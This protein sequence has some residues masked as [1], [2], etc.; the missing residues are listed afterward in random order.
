MRIIDT[1]GIGDTT[2]NTEKFMVALYEALANIDGELSCIVMV[3]RFP[4]LMNAEYRN[5]LTFYRDI[6]SEVYH[7]SLITFIAVITII[8]RITAALLS[9]LHRGCCRYLL[10]YPKV[11]HK[12]VIVVLNAFKHDPEWQDL[13]R[14][15]LGSDPMET[16][17]LLEEEVRA[18]FKNDFYY[19]LRAFDPLGAK[20]IDEE[21]A[22]RARKL[23][24]D[25]STNPGVN[26]RAM[27]FPKP[28]TWRA[29][30]DDR[31]VQL[32]AKRSSLQLK[33]KSNSELEERDTTQKYQRIQELASLESDEDYL[34]LSK[35][36]EKESSFLGWAQSEFNVT[37]K[38]P[39]RYSFSVVLNINS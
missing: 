25:C 33:L 22:R 37:T 6:L 26:V 9:I 19:L 29:I 39:I 13:Q 17:R 38:H 31:I 28:S 30:D 34:I 18:F 21:E 1:V 12:N 4:S 2:G 32:K 15:T 23:I 5:N 36:F 27:K 7:H 3:I 8:R 35:T 24:L 16:L 11:F 14:D 10:Y 20:G